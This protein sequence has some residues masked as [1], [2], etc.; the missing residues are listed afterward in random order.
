MLFDIRGRRKHVVRVVYAILALLMGA[1]LFLVVGPVNLGS[2]AGGGGTTEASKILDEQAEEAEAR[3]RRDEDNPNLL[4]AVVRARVGAGNA[5]TEV[6]PQTGAP[7]LNAEGRQD[8]QQAAGIWKVYLEETDEVN[9]SGALLMANTFFTLAEAG[10]SLEE[11]ATNIEGAATAQ[12]LA[13]EARPATGFLTTLASYEYLAGNFKAGDAAGEKAK[14]KATA[15]EKKQVEEQ[16]AESR[17]RGKQWQNEKKRFAKTEKEQ[18][19]EALQNPFG[20][21]GGTSEGLG[22]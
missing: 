7:V 16:I 21:L 14:A 20:G 15:Q 22:E 2:L 5:E 6:N 3:L 18:G 4:L 19:K 13:T 8:F 11:I 17:Q 1:S 10:V 12:R 9:P